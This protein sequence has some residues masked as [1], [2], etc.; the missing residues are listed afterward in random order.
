MLRPDDIEVGIGKRQ[1]QRAPLPKDRPFRL[2]N[3]G[4]QHFGDPTILLGQIQPYHL[5]ANGG[6]QIPARSSQTTTDVEQHVT[7]SYLCPLCQLFGSRPSAD[8]E[9]V[10]GRQVIDRQRLEVLPRR[11][12]RRKDSIPKIANRVML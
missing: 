1:G 11:L 10:N 3:S 6:C 4:R 12:K 9:R 8:V 7:R 5:T 2:A